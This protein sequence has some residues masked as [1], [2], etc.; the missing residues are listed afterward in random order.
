MKEINNENYKMANL[1]R[2]IGETP[3][4]KYINYFINYAFLI[5]DLLYAFKCE[6]LEYLKSKKNDE[7]S[8]PIETINKRF[9]NYS[10]EIRSNLE[11]LKKKRNQSDKSEILPKVVDFLIDNA[12][13]AIIKDDINLL[14]SHTLPK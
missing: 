1:A 12:E 6:K 11:F 10:R 5:K 9:E 14:Y 3:N 7:F 4:N 13:K 2:V 8:L